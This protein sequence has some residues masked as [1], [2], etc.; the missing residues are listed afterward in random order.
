ML[1][2]VSPEDIPLEHCQSVGSWHV[3]RAPHNIEPVLAV[4]VD[5]LDVVQ[6][7]VRPVD[8]L[9]DEVQGNPTGLVEGVSDQSLDKRAVHV[10]PQDLVV[11]S[12]EHQADLR[13]QGDVRGRREVAGHDDG[14][15]VRSDAEY[16]DLLS[17]RVHHVEVVGY[18]VHGYGHRGPGSSN[19]GNV[20]LSII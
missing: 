12:D 14:V 16:V 10:S 3:V 20:Y 19:T 4:V 5:R 9:G 8:S 6:E 17:Q 7:D 1:G 2:I 13:V 11:V 18:P 15:V